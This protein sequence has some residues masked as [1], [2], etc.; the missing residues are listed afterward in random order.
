MKRKEKKEGETSYRLYHLL[1]SQLS[2]FTQFFL[3]LHLYFSQKSKII[4]SPIRFICVYAPFLLSIW[5]NF[6]PSEETALARMSNIIITL[7]GKK[8]L[9]GKIEFEDTL[10]RYC[11]KAKKMLRFFF[12]TSK[13][14]NTLSSVSTHWNLKHLQYTFS[15]KKIVLIKCLFHH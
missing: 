3:S 6:F 4:F 11:R 14:K 12:C 10:F 7:G 9:R 13:K 15:K 2:F 8:T 5:V 1:I